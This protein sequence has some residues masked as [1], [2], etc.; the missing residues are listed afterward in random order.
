[1]S[2]E[3]GC[4]SRAYPY[5]PSEILYQIKDE[6]SEI[7]IG[8]DD[9]DVYIYRFRIY[10]AALDTAKVLRNFI[11]DGK[12]VDESINRYNRNCIFYDTQTGEYSPY[13]GPDRTLDPVRL[14]AKIPDVKILML[15]T[16]KFTTS[17]K[18]F[19]ANS[20]LRCIHAEGGK[21][22]PSR[23]VQDNWLF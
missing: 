18:D 19:V 9:C 2:Y 5:S 21:V 13:E 22:Y 3:D 7:T 1:M 4:P 11:A 10:S 15:D 14:A 20:T 6:E 8:S 23:G 12:D 17:K 16:P